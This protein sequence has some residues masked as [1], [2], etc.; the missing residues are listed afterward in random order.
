MVRYVDLA[1]TDLRRVAGFGVAGNFAGHLEQAGE[2]SDFT[3]VVAAEGAPKGMFPFYVPGRSG[4]L[5]TFPM[6]FD[7]IAAPAVDGNL[8]IEPEVAL[9]CDLRYAAGRVVEVRPRA[10]GAYN[11]CSIRREG[12][13]RISEKKNWGPDSKGLARRFVELDG[14]A[15][16]SN[17][18][19]YRLASFLVRDGEA[20]PY[21]QDSPL[22]G[23]SYYGTRLLD[24]IVD[25]LAHQQGSDETPL[26][27]IGDYLA[28]AGHPEAAV[29]GIGATRYTEFGETTFLRPGDRSVVVVYDGAHYAPGEIEAA[30]GAEDLPTE[31]ISALVQT[32]HPSNATAPAPH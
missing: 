30:A 29:I 12:A 26:E 20:T 17:A 9:L 23:Y 8:Q 2:A 14:F 16:D 21:G 24:W 25:R 4:Y 27:P 22:P 6:S 19:S 1:E 15:A 31:H 7:R 32:V 11:D 18:N 13:R 28:D 3:N 10:F 5:G